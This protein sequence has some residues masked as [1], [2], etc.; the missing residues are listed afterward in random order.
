MIKLFRPEEIESL[1]C[2]STEPLNITEL[3]QITIYENYTDS[4]DIIK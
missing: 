1:V 2:G 4:D 3:R